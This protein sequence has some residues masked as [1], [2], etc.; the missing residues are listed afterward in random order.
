MHL[1]NILM[2]GT[3]HAQDFL[4]LLAETLEG[5][6]IGMGHQRHQNVLQSETDTSGQ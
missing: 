4:P 2:A 5:G 1:A 6:Q 3:L